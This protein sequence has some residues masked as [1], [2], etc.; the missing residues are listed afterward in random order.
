MSAVSLDSKTANG[1]TSMTP[2]DLNAMAKRDGNP[3]HAI[4]EAG[5]KLVAMLLVEDMKCEA[6]DVR[7]VLKSIRDDTQSETE[8]AA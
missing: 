3:C 2:D 7:Q 1:V 8:R 6:D 4:L 5:D